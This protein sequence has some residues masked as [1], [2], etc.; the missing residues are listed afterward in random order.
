VEVTTMK[1]MTTITDR[2]AQRENED[3]SRERPAQTRFVN[4]GGGFF[5]DRKTGQV[6]AL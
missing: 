5:L 4:L 3:A 6:I 2:K 1:T